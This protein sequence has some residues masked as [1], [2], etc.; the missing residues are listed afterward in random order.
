MTSDPY[1][2]LQDVL[3]K[4]GLKAGLAF[5]N[6]R[7]PHRFTAIYRLDNMLLRQVELVDKGG[8]PV[9]VAALEAIPL[10]TSFCQFVL[11]DGQFTTSQSASDSRLDGHP[12]QGVV[13]SYIG[14]PL[15][16][17]GDKLFG[18]FCHFDFC[19]QPVND[20]EFAFLQRVVRLLP[21][22]L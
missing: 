10:E 2:S 19:E 6:E 14:L 20:E 5:L 7:V 18:T 4:Q 12:Y 15:Q 8:S 22:Y 17:D 21:R 16:G 9:D 1:Q 13:D 11:S 3:Q